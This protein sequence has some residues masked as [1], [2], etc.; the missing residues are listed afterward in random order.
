MKLY[1]S[2]S[3]KEIIDL[4]ANSIAGIRLPEITSSTPSTS[5]KIASVHQKQPEAKIA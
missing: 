4:E 1:G 3:K 2:I 5:S